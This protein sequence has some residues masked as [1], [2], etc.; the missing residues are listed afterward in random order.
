MFTALKDILSWLLGFGAE[1]TTLRITKLL[2]FPIKSCK[3][4]S[5][6]ET[7]YTPEGLENDRTI[8]IIDAKS[9]SA[10]TARELSKML[11]IHPQIRY[12]STD[13]YGGT[14]D[15]S[16]PQD[17]D[18]QAFSIPL[19]P[20]DELLESW[21]L[22]EDV[23]VWSSRNDGHI[24]RSIDPD[25]IFGPDTPSE[26]ISNFLGRNVLLV[27]KGPRPRAVVATPAFPDLKTTTA[28]QDG[29]PLLIASESS[30]RDI[31]RHIR[32]AATD[33]DGKL[34]IY[35]LNK[36]VW[37]DKEFAM[38]R[39]RPNIVINGDDALPYDEERWEEIK[40]GELSSGDA[41]KI[42]LIPNMDIE[43]AE[44]DKSVPSQNIPFTDDAYW[45]QYV[46]LFDSPSD[47]SSLISPHDIRRAIDEAPEN[48]ETLIT[49]LSTRLFTLIT[50]HTFPSPPTSS[51]SPV[52]N[53]TAT[54]GSVSGTERRDPT[55]EA[56]NC[57]RVL[58]RILP[59]V[60]EADNSFEND[61]FWKRK[62]TNVDA[63][64]GTDR[65]GPQFVI[66]EDDSDDEGRPSRQPAAGTARPNAVTNEQLEK[67]LAE[68]LL[69]STI[70]L[71]FCCGF[72]L[73]SKLQVDHH[74]INYTIWER[75]IGSSVDVVGNSQLDSNKAEVLRFLEIL[76]SK[77]I[78]TS[79]NS[80][81]LISNP[82]VSQLVHDH[83]TP[84]R[85]V[86]PM[87]CSLLNTAMNSGSYSNAARAP[88]TA[89]GSV[90]S[91]VNGVG[92]MVTNL[93]Y[94]HLI[95]RDD[96]GP[97]LVSL[98]FGVLLS[99]LD[100]QAA[101]A[102]DII[103][104]GEAVT[105]PI[106][107]SP[108]TSDVS[109]APTAVTNSFRYFL[110]KLHRPSDLDYILNGIL[111]I[112]GHHI[113]ATHNM[114]P[115]SRKIVPHTLE[116]FLFLWK[117]IELNKKFRSH[118]FESDR[119]GDVLSYLLV[120]CLEHK[121]K[122]QHHGL[123]R[124]LS[125]IVQCLSA[126]TDFGNQL[127][128]PIPSR[129]SIPSRWVTQGD[130]GDFFVTSIYW[131]VAT[132]SG[133]LN[134][135]YPALI[136]ALANAAPSLTNLQVTSSNRLVQLFASFSN[137]SFLLSDESHPRLVFFILEVLNQ[138]IFHQ[139]SSNP[140]LAYAI[141][142]SHKT[143]ENLGTFTLSKGLREIRRVK[144]AKEEAERI[145]AGK[146]GDK[147]K[148]VERT[149]SARS[150]IRAH[151][152]GSRVS[153]TDD[154]SIE[155]A[156]LSRSTSE[157]V[158]RSSQDE[159]ADR[160]IPIP[161]TPTERSLSSLQ[162]ASPPSVS[163][164][165]EK[166]RGKM[167]AGQIHGDDEFDPELE[168]I[169]AV[170]VGRNGFVPTQEWVTSWQESLPLDTVLVVISELLPKVRELQASSSQS[171]T[172]SAILDYLKMVEIK[173]VLP[174]APPLIPRRFQW[175]DASLVWLSSLIWGE[176]FVKGTSP[177]GIWNSTNVKLFG[178]RHTPQ[179]RGVSNFVG[180][181]LSSATGSPATPPDPR[182][183]HSRR[184]SRQS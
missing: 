142:R 118:V 25:A 48:L 122:P 29:Y 148:G 57:F 138:I 51:F 98:S 64:I 67:P 123:V 94:Q 85:L 179:T 116:T 87:L 61:V 42:L 92:G 113:S 124:A 134:F 49:V 161:E 20:D 108:S 71:M 95:M 91:M 63:D 133:Q 37:K 46:L 110:A 114:L 157:F 52:A 70:D 144:E 66:E 126:E 181:L 164:I 43:T 15:I 24:I 178:V 139:F 77:T 17:S 2:V 72:T 55:K 129:V 3:G 102:R 81:L 104:G 103:S 38:E 180:G 159:V 143:F 117:M 184:P 147:G 75:G 9:H 158:I 35:G 140:N 69:S 115:G 4:T 8:A 169:A 30:L 156:P 58:G 175:S 155:K 154:Q 5:V 183:N 96:A 73:P 153:L 45:S 18:C 39:F 21:P 112:L 44:P 106:V 170:G 150:S 27:R 93:P 88:L 23:R 54:W 78:Y 132:T 107:P 40:V 82:Y 89:M 68:K 120:F 152:P 99:L 16:F 165:S 127:S 176:I 59:V 7:R 168:R 172:T 162:I 145:Q 11:L 100:Y 177:L 166:A 36:E 101:E 60:F 131:M 173:T 47:V 121:E 97:A 160:P 86:L 50:D 130:L 149:T 146:G 174:S 10:V 109:A 19:N 84:R 6:Q 28:F 62:R 137:P 135:L 12:D 111:G 32:T 83:H 26:T 79:P 41:G 13:L 105:S 56:L 31:T 163:G 141:L 53:I 1:Q 33:E 65:T 34:K 182:V 22:A 14:I 119:L 90:G 171:K 80:L 136:I 76:L 151:S 125:Y 167:K 128:Q 74:K